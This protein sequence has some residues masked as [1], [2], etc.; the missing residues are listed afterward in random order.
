M[1]CDLKEKLK[2]LVFTFSHPPHVLLAVKYHWLGAKDYWKMTTVYLVDLAALIHWWWNNWMAKVEIGR[3]SS[4]QLSPERYLASWVV[5]CCSPSVKLTLFSHAR[6]LHFVGS[7][8]ALL[9][10]WYRLRCHTPK[11]L[12]PLT[13]SYDTLYLFS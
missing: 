2:V 9:L 11:T 6:D 4:K 10:W 3:Q 8:K 7:G 12:R 13:Y 1:V 5:W